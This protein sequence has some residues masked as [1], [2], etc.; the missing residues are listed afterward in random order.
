[1]YQVNN[2]SL[3][4]THLSRIQ[5]DW[6]EKKVEWIRI[7]LSIIVIGSIIVSQDFKHR[8][9]RIVMIVFQKKVDV[10]IVRAE[11]R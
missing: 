9:V 6:V 7:K 11:E 3:V 4:N 1:M 8:I 2:L 10:E 5:I